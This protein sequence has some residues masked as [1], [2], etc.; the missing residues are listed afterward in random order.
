MAHAQRVP[1]GPAESGD[2]ITG[3]AFAGGVAWSARGRC[4]R[5]GRQ[6]ECG[7]GGHEGSV[8]RRASHGGSDAPSERSRLRPA[9]VARSAPAP[10]SAAGA[11]AQAANHRWR[12]ARARAFRRAAP[13]DRAGR[14]RMSCRLRQTAIAMS[15]QQCSRPRVSAATPTRRPD[16]RRGAFRRATAEI[17][18]VVVAADVRQLM[19]EQRLDLRLSSGR[20]ARRPGAGRP[21]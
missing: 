15:S 20:R 10:A 2:T 14:G 6:L 1:S 21:A 3:V 12:R 5:S 19:R 16:D 7:R 11:H 4:R 9:A 8:E 17:H 13:R 18:E